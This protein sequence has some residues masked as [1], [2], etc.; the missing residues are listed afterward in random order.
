MKGPWC[1]SVM[2]SSRAA[3]V[4]AKIS[5]RRR[6]ASSRWVRSSSTPRVATAAATATPSS[7]T[8]RGATRRKGKGRRRTSG[9]IVVGRQLGEQGVV[10]PAAGDELGLAGDALEA[11]SQPLDDAQ[12]GVVL[13]GGSAA[14]AV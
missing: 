14:H 9:R 4:T 13:G 2:A 1:S 11:K 10:E 6:A 3:Q 8:T 12:A 7:T 5:L